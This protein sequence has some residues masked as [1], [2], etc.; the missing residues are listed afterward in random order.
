MRDLFRFIVHIFSFQNLFLAGIIFSGLSCSLSTEEISTDPN[1]KLRFST[2]TIFFDT[3]FTEIA[4]VTKRLRVYNDHNNAVNIASIHLFEQDSDK[5]MQP[6]PE[7]IRTIA[8]VIRKLP[9]KTSCL[10]ECLIVHIYFRGQGIF[11]PIY[12]GIKKS[13][14]LH[15]HAWYL[16]QNSAGFNKI[17]M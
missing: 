10:E 12:L 11:I 6:N 14:G 9:G 1:H 7:V 17:S 8:K 4:S 16:E 2:D 15:A 5:K 3:V 13:D